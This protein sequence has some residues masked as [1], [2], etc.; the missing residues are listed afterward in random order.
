MRSIIDFTR[1]HTTLQSQ[2]H[3]QNL[4]LI[5]WAG[6]GENDGISDVERLPNYD[7]Y[8]CLGFQGPRFDKNVA[9][10]RD[11]QTI[12]II[13]IHDAEQM[14][15]FHSV[16]AGSF[17]H[18][19]SDYRG[20][21]PT[22]PLSYYAT[23]LVPNGRAFHT[24]GING[25]RMPEED[26]LNTLEIFAPVL[27]PELAER[28]RWSSGIIG[29]AKMDKLTPGEVWASPDLKQPYYSGIIEIQD[30]F[31]QWQTERNGAWP[32]CAQTLKG[33]WASLADRVLFWGMTSDVRVLEVIQPYLQA[34]SDHLSEKIDG[35]MLERGLDTRDYLTECEKMT[36]AVA[37]IR[38]RQKVF[39]WLL[40]EVPPG[41][42]AKIGYYVDTRLPDGPPAFGLWYLR[43]PEA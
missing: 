22:L 14:A 23:L 11:S 19:D 13:N 24:E 39:K 31:I 20:N 26:F 27:S 33:Q 15:R 10:L 12:C 4:R 38:I 25:L 40:R 35:L 5:L 41:L 7:V 32:L 18:I 37:A 2:Q 43:I 3:R 29:L 30:R 1:P 16:F 42:L 6:D 9:S 8:L 28:R 17:A 34:F 21:T 36:D